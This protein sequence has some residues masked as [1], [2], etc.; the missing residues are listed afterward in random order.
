VRFRTT[1]F[2]EMSLELSSTTAPGKVFESREDI[3]AHYKSDW[4][5]YNLKRREAGLP[6]LLETDFLARFE[7]AKATL[8]TNEKQAGTNHLKQQKQ[9]NKNNNVVS[10]MSGDDKQMTMSKVDAA[11]DTK[12]EQ[13]QEAAASAVTETLTDGDTD[14]LQQQMQQLQIQIDPRQCLFDRHVSASV[15]DN[16]TRMHRKYGFFVPDAEYLVDPAGLVGFC[17][18]KIKLGHMCLYC[19]RV[20]ATYRAC[21]QH[22]MS[23]NHTKLLYQAGYD[24]EDLAVFYDFTQADDEFMK[25]LGTAERA[26]ANDEENDN[27]ADDED[28]ADGWED[29][30]D[31]EAAVDDDQME[32]GDDD[33]DELYSGYEDEVRRMGFTVTELGELVFPD[34]RIVGHRALRRYYKQ[35]P[36]QHVDSAAVV[37]A[38]KS[39]GER[40]VNGR[41]YNIRTTGSDIAVATNQN[42][43]LALKL[44]GVAPGLAVGRMG[45]G[46]LTATG[47]DGS[48][49][50]LSVYRYRAAVRKQ[51]R[52]EQVGKRAFERTNQ[53]MNRMDKKANRLMNGVSVAHA[54]R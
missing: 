12:E 13:P 40:L 54:A 4:H 49:S 24:L 37:A 8:R 30:S 19:E 31:D 14:A 38:R 34:G 10:A 36:Q 23:K 7:A 43:Q 35:R 46:I 52:G 22:M 15:Q 32:D 27:E 51:R 1:V 50:Q 2:I 45:Q 20:F 21:Q 11:E 48:F 44:A 47:P 41:V 26:N 39:A 33:D 5:K 3:A 42:A 25:H 29:V 16:L 53:N 9:G 18:E 6:L 28:A 17:H